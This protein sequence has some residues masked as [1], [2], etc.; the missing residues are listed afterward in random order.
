MKNMF[1]YDNIY[2]VI[3][4]SGILLYNSIYVG[5]IYI[6]GYTAVYAVDTNTLIL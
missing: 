6:I 1:N 4:T 2:K 5:I 3:I